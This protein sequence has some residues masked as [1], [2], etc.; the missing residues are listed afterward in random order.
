MA[1][2]YLLVTLVCC[3]MYFGSAHASS[4]TIFGSSNVTGKLYSLKFA[5]SYFLSFLFYAEVRLV[6]GN[7][8]SGRVEIRPTT[9]DQFGQAC[10]NG[11]TNT[12]ATVICRQ[13]GCSTEE[14]AVV[15]STEYVTSQDHKMYEALSLTIDQFKFAWCTVLH[16]S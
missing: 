4:D 13:L 9:L 2:L 8:C 3:S 12:E 16:H 15:P 10:D 7:S 5:N 11:V 14:A 6:G 1:T